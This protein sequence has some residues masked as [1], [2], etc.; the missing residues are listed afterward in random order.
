MKSRRESATPNLLYQR[1]R[2]IAL[3][4]YGAIL[5]AGLVDWSYGGISTRAVISAPA[6][7][8][9]LALE[10]MV[11]GLIVLEWRAVGSGNFGKYGQV[12]WLAL[13]AR[14]LLVVG[15]SL[16]TAL[17]YTEILLLPVLLYCYLAVG[18]RWSYSIAILAVAALFS[19]KLFGTLPPPSAR[20][21]GGPPPPSYGEVLPSPRNHAPPTPSGPR[22]DYR[23]SIGR[24]IN[25]GMELLITAFFTLL[26]ARAMLQAIQAQ[27]KLTGLL[28]S[29][30]AS[31][32]QLREYSTQIADLATTEER[33]RLARDI[34]DSLGHHLAAI[35]IQ[36]EKANAYRDR[37]LDRAYG[38]VHQAQRAAQ[39]A[40]KDVRTSVGS[41]RQDSAPFLFEEALNDLVK[42][43]D[44][45]K[46]KLE[47]RQSGD[48]SRYE[49]LKL[50]ILY[51]VIQEGLTNVHKHA[52][53]SQAIITVDFG[54]QQVTLELADNGCGFDAESWINNERKQTN[55]SGHQGLRGLQE[56]LS[57]VG[58]TFAIKSC[59]QMTT[60]IA[61]IPHANAQI[62]NNFRYT[63]I[64]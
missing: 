16:V 57:L 10:T 23:P 17:Y 38:A 62:K 53:A 28:T 7:Y 29:L 20:P 55:Q 46:L 2:V 31:N 43:M 24:T 59:P 36:L 51:R 1:Y 42:R 21:R 50:I 34:H 56:R 61:R 22:G 63:G 35:N 12:E 4:V 54:P 33:N 37:D 41:L 25:Q 9:F 40:L 58:G 26:L 47:L 39:D 3:A 60:L 11:V 48:S 64:L 15:V 44:H 45:S 30:E 27:Q 32:T 6:I 49:K 5:L 13:L 18:K 8:R 19:L 52:Q 14:L